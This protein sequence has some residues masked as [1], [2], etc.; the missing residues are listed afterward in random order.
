MENT[1]VTLMSSFIDLT[2]EEKQGIL[3]AFPIK[4]YPPKTNLL[5]EGQIAKDAFFV[6]K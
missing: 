5:R 1:M 2:E 6:I 3:E 4:T